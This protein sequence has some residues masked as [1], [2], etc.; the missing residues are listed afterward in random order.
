MRYI[1]LLPFFSR[2]HNFHSWFLEMYL[3]VMKLAYIGISGAVVYILRFKEAYKSTYD[4]ARDDF[5]HW[6]F[7]A[8]PCGAMALILNY[9]WSSSTWT[10]WFVEVAWA[11]SQYL[12]AVA[13]FPQS[14][15][16]KRH[17]EVENITSNY[18]FSLGVY[19]VLYVLNWI[20][21][22]MTRAHYR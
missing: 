5:P 11:F 14:V 19:R 4:A 16:M 2:H 1:D 8:A 9:G 10:A 20:W 22:L 7:L 21:K 15:L 17:K 13:I 12:E 3:P 6:L 18:V